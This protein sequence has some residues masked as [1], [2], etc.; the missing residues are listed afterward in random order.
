MSLALRCQDTWYFALAGKVCP[1]KSRRNRLCPAKDPAAGMTWNRR[2]V[3]GAK[4]GIMFMVICIF[5]TSPNMIIYIDAW[6]SR[7]CQM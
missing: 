3:R 4:D 1:S 7:S 5:I 6:I 2:A